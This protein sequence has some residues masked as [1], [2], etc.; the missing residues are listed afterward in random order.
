MSV[1]LTLNV[2]PCFDFKVK[3]LCSP[4]HFSDGPLAVVCDSA[5]DRAQ[6]TRARHSVILFFF[7]PE[8]G[9]LWLSWNSLCRPGWPLPPEYWD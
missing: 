8:I 3:T 4:P 5:G 6:S 2:H 7:F 1:D 9:F